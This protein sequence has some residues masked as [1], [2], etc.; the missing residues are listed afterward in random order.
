MRYPK[1]ALGIFLYANVASWL[2]LIGS[3][4]IALIGFGG[5]P[6]LNINFYLEGLLLNLL[7]LVLFFYFSVQIERQKPLDFIEQLTQLFIT[8]LLTNTGALVVQFVSTTLQ[9]PP[10]TPSKIQLINWLY[11]LNIVFVS[12]FLTQTFFYWKRMILHQKS[13]QIART[14]YTF[15]YILLASLIF[16]FFDLGFSNTVFAL[17]FIA[18]TLLGLRL[19]VN[20]KWVAYLNAKEK[21]QGILLLLFIAAFTF[22]FFR[23]VI[24]HSENEH[25]IVDLTH[26]LYILSLGSFVLFYTIFSLLVI[27]F[28]LPTTSVFERKLEEIVSFQ[29]L[30]HSLRI[31]EQEEQ[32]YQTLLDA[33]VS[34]IEIDAAWLD[35]HDDH[36]N[37]KDT[38]Y[39][40]ITADTVHQIKQQLLA[41]RLKQA[42]HQAF[43]RR[44]TLDEA[45]DLSGHNYH[46]LLVIPM[47][48]HQSSMGSLFLLHRFKDAFDKEKLTRTF[49]MQA[50]V[51][52]ENFRLLHKTIRQE[53]Y[54]EEI[55]IAR[56]VQQRL[57][58]KSL[59]IAPNI[60]VDAFSDSAYEVGGDYY[61]F[62][63]IDE[64]RTLLIIGDISGKG[65][66]AAFNMAQLKGIFHGVSSLGLSP[67]ELLP[68]LNQAVSA[69]FDRKAFATATLALIDNEAHTVQLTR[70]GH[71][72]TLYY[73]AHTQ[74][75]RYLMG[76]GLGL[77][78]L[79]NGSY[80]AHVD[81]QIFSYQS[82]D[83]LFFYTDGVVEAKNQTGEEYGYDRLKTLIS[84]YVTHSVQDINQQ[85][86]Q[87]LA[88][89]TQDT[90]IHDDHTVLAIRFL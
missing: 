76:E 40:H 81:P 77:G 61:D 47:V 4:V 43:E 42:L 48:S 57:L 15:E 56:T 24:T 9:V 63:R 89:F 11:Y 85:I 8:G 19:S 29:K 26:S 88:R 23:T 25:L 39:R 3:N 27:I 58:P 87:D 66:S 34:T 70:A 5:K 22:Y 50:G 31:E 84:S 55:K 59:F 52:I 30:A 13:S 21:W 33:V 68:S 80:A 67:Q 28:N 32:V 73:C 75:L 69:C 53:R 10:I 17:S 46:S 1:N 18:L 49:V 12:I 37:L 41:H 45:P 16:N 62:Y 72:P 44:H 6:F 83:M 35:I 38:V 51:S 74:T 86:L 65:T 82:G 64:H 78:I 14:W 71:C 7:F 60:E 79:R 36:G 2:L 20:L 90:P 54:Q